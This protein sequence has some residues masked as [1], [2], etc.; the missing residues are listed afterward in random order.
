MCT[1]DE[2]ARLSFNSSKTGKDEALKCL[3]R[4][5]YTYRLKESFSKSI[6][7]FSLSFFIYNCILY[8]LSRFPCLDPWKKIPQV[9]KHRTHMRITFDNLARMPLI[10]DFPF[11]VTSVFFSLSPSPSFPS[12]SRSSRHARKKWNSEE[13]FFPRT[14]FLRDGDLMELKSFRD[15]HRCALYSHAARGTR[16]KNS[17]RA[18]KESPDRWSTIWEINYRARRNLAEI[19]SHGSAV[20]IAVVALKRLLRA[21]DARPSLR[22]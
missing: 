13:F 19:I 18:K 12:C 1:N 14:R 4:N 5:Y 9:F 6:T 16:R 17:L 11:V 21:L 20:V 10:P 22:L 15:A 7:L 8:T 3:Y 2:R